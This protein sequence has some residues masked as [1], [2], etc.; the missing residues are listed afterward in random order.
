M[1][2]SRI[3]ESLWI[4]WI[5]DGY[6]RVFGGDTLVF[7]TS[8]HV[9][10]QQEV[11]KRALAS[12]YQREGAVDSLGQGYGAVDRAHVTHGYAGKLQGEDHETVCDAD[13]LTYYGEQVDTPLPVTWVEVIT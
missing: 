8:T 13:G 6:E 5:G 11:V 12:A 1:R 10:T 7:Y 2:D 3:G 4:E 9:D